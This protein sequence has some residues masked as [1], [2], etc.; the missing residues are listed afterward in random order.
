MQSETEETP[1]RMDNYE[2]LGC[3]I[4][5]L[6]WNKNVYNKNQFDGALNVLKQYG[7]AERRE[8]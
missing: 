2:F 1:G 7:A 8:A 3:K 6:I 4:F 5:T